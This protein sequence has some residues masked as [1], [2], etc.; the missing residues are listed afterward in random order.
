MTTITG[1]VAHTQLG[2]DLVD[3]E[4]K[5]DG[6][7]YGFDCQITMPFPNTNNPPIDI[8]LIPPSG[9]F[10]DA[11]TWTWVPTYK[12]VAVGLDHS[13]TTL[14]VWAKTHQTGVTGIRTIATEYAFIPNVWHVTADDIE[15]EGG[16]GAFQPS[17][18]GGGGGTEV[19]IDEVKAAVREV[20]G[21]A[22]G[23]SLADEW[24]AGTQPNSHS[25]D[26]RQVLEDKS[27]SAISESNV[28]TT[29]NIKDALYQFTKDREYEVFEQN[30]PGFWA[31]L[32][33]K[34]AGTEPTEEAK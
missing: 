27:K 15:A 33:G 12:A 4:R 31:W 19:T 5:T 22:D 17:G 34:V 24:G 23:R 1:V 25:R 7:G 16:A 6:A 30:A 8:R 10:P 14:I 13:G 9:P 29:A 26:W 20:I 2:G 11:P 3:G 28:T 18:G 32:R 21:I